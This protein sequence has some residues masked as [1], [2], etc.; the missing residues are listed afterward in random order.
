MVEPNTTERE[1][2]VV[3]PI[4]ITPKEYAQNTEFSPL[5][6]PLGAMAITFSELEDKLTMAINALLKIDHSPD[7]IILEDLMQSFSGRRKLFSSLVA[8]KTKGIVRE[9][10]LKKGGLDSQLMQCNDY[11]NNF[12]HGRWTGWRSDGSFIKVRY[13]ADRNGLNVVEST[14]RVEVSNIWEAQA[15]VFD[16]ALELST[17]YSVFNSPDRPDLWPATWRDKPTG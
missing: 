5:N 3:K 8:I 13:H 11:R 14:L 12:L 10:V 6:E 15:K 9:K 4:S 16:T 2:L 17:W 1:M 7:G